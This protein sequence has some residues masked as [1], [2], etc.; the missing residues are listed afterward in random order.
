MAARLRVF[1]GMLA[2]VA[3]STAVGQIQFRADLDDAKIAR[4]QANYQDAIEAL[5]N[6]RE[7]FLAAYRSAQTDRDK[8]EV[9]RAVR[10][11]ISDA[12]LTR[13]FPAWYGTEWDFNG[14]SQ[15]PGEGQIACGYFVTTT[16]RDVGFNLQRVK[17]AQQPSQRIIETLSDSE[18]VKIL[19][20]KPMADIEAYI[21]QS[22][23]GIYIGRSRYAYRVYCERR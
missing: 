21:K 11:E 6:S 5:L 19:Y 4:S 20:E 16:L 7:G 18:D 22:G 1:V 23:I 17:L 9:I 13:V 12:L 3:A 10:N 15:K 2:L 14:V 8:S